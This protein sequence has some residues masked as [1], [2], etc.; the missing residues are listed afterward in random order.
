MEVEP[1]NAFP[2]ENFLTVDGVNDDDRKH[3]HRKA[4]VATPIE[5]ED[6]SNGWMV[7]RAAVGSG[8]STAK[9][10]SACHS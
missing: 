5:Y 3:C 9:Q 10:A 8:E 4:K 7:G 1:N 6:P 2:A